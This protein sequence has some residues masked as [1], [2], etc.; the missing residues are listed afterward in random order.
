MGCKQQLRNFEKQQWKGY[1]T[2]THTREPITQGTYD[3]QWHN[4]F[5]IQTIISQYNN[6]SPV[7]QGPQILHY[8]PSIICA[9][10]PVQIKYSRG[11]YGSVLCGDCL[12]FP[13]SACAFPSR[14]QNIWNYGIINL[15]YFCFQMVVQWKHVRMYAVSMISF[16]CVLKGISPKENATS[17]GNMMINIDEPSSWVV[18]HNLKQT[19]FFF[20]I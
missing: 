7:S 12:F 13:L 15:W 5:F 19:H 16:G 8:P 6:T 11:P 18:P 2:Y 20:P 4:H 9:E 17:I 14:K 3:V 10:S 1:Q